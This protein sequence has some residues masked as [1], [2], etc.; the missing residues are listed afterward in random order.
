MIVVMVA[1]PRGPM[2]EALL[3]GWKEQEAEWDHENAILCLS[4]QRPKF[5]SSDFLLAMVVVAVEV[6]FA[7]TGAGPRARAGPGPV[8]S[9]V[10][11]LAVMPGLVWRAS[12]HRCR[13]RCR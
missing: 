11:G 10:S 13:R 8:V 3:V 9:R 7:R 6:V 2:E 1:E 4:L 5:H 12:V